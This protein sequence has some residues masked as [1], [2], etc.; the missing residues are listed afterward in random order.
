MPLKLKQLVGLEERTVSGV[1]FAA[2]SIAGSIVFNSASILDVLDRIA[3]L[4]PDEKAKIGMRV[5]NVVF[6]K[7]TMEAT[8]SV[9]KALANAKRS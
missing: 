4:V 2:Y 9:A 5:F 8:N 6:A 3:E 7:A 1:K